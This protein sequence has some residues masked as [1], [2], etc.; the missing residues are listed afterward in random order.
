M[1]KE[2]ATTLEAYQ[3]KAK[4][5]IINSIEHDNLDMEKAKHKREKLNSFIKENFSTLPKGAN[6][7]EIGSADG[8]NAKYIE[9]L[10][11]QV[12]ASDVAD[13]FIETTK[14]QIPN[15]I[16][17]DVLNNEFPDTYYGIFCWRVFVHFTKEDV[18]KVLKKVY[19]ALENGGIF[20][21]NAINRE[22]RSVDSEWVDFPGEYHMGIDRYYN[23]YRQEELDDIISKT[24]FE[25]VKF[26]K[27]GGENQNKWLVYVL[28]KRK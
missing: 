3:K 25:T 14:N 5:Y 21:F 9:S 13:Y 19:N 1:S 26:H 6:V 15:T 7:F 28:K 22:T 11:Y 2:N 16:K 8:Q 10:G 24:P 12:T 17:F 20:I 18:L 23:Y 4:Q 27:E